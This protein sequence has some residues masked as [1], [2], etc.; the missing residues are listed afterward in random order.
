MQQPAPVLK[1]WFHR[2]S[3]DDPAA[4]DELFRA[5]YTGLVRFA[6]LF[7]TDSGKAE[8]VV[9]DVFVEI[10]LHRQSL[11]SVDH[12]ITYLYVSVKNRCLNAKRTATRMVSIEEETAVSQS[13]ATETPL[14]R[15]E[16]NELS[17]NLR[18]IVEQLPDQQ[19]TVFKMIREQELTAKQTAQILHLSQRTVETHLYKAIQQ[20]EAEITAYLGYSPRKRQMKKML[21][22]LV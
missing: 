12:P 13:A 18:A 5:K 19:K 9:S 14:S 4:F 7:L 8:E 1:E 21:S 20:L 16:D 2:I 15:M 11:S 3:E 22:V 6:G 17:A 10:W